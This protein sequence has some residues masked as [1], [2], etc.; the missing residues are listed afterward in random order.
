MP[1]MNSSRG[2]KGRRSAFGASYRLNAAVRSPQTVLLQGLIFSS[3]TVF[4]NFRSRKV[5]RSEEQTS[6]LQSLIRIS[7]AVFCLT[8]KNQHP[9]IQTKNYRKNWPQSKSR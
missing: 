9:H 1:S 7:Y 2:R 8:K 5:S 3:R 6:E 4:P